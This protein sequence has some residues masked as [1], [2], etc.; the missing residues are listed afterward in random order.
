MV[1]GVTKLHP[2]KNCRAKGGLATLLSKDRFG[3]IAVTSD[4]VVKI[5]RFVF[6]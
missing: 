3:A 6:Y 1:E 4:F 5:K 2:D